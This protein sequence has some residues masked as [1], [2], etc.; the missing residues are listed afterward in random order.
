MTDCKTSEFARANERLIDTITNGRPDSNV[1]HQILGAVPG[2]APSFSPATSMGTI[3]A[4]K[5]IM[6][7]LSRIYM[8]QQEQILVFL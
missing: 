6:E 4:K 1:R 8:P 7:G 2:A 5:K 3:G